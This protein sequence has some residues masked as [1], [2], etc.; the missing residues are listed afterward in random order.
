MKIDLRG[1]FANPIDYIPR[2][3]YNN[4]QLNKGVH[5]IVQMSVMT[6]SMYCVMGVFFVR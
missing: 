5:Q 3:M 4:L 6:H 2:F 1:K